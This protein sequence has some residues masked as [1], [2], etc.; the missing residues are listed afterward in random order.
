MI[1]GQI[2]LVLAAA[3]AGAAFYINVAEQPARLGLD[4]KSLLMEWKP[5]YAGGFAMQGTLAVMSAI[6]GFAAAWLT[7]DWRWLIGAALILAN[8]PYTLFGMMPTNNKLKAIAE[9]DAGP[10]ARKMIESWGRLHAIRTALGISATL[11]YLWALN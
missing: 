6:M 9:N 4:D 5:S 7:K 2:A 10:V 11:A 1:A 3:F 8:W